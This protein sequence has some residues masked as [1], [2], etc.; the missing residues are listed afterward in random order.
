MQEALLKQFEP[1]VVDMILSIVNSFKLSGPFKPAEIKKQ[2]SD[3]QVVHSERPSPK[4]SQFEL[5]VQ[6]IREERETPDRLDTAKVPDKR[7]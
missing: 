3:G 6:P 2:A 7:A 1:R 5:A 4:S